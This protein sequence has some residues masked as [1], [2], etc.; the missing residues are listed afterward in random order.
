[1][2]A[3]EF[4]WIV[5]SETGRSAEDFARDPIIAGAGNASPST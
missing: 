4:I 3:I 5:L 1:M 2:M